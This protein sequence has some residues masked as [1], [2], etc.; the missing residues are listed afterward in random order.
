[1]VGQIVEITNP[2][3]WLNKHRGFLEVRHDGEKL[4]QVPLDDIAAI[5]ISVPGCSVSTN[6][7]D[8]LAQRNIPIAI[9]GQ[10]YLPSTWMLPVQGYN[11]QFHVMRAQTNITEPKRKRA[12][13]TIIKAKI[14][15]QAEVLKRAGKSPIRLKWL[16]DN[17]RS[18]DPENFEAQA[19]R[20]Y[21]QELFGT[22]FRR[23]REA[24]GINAALNYSYAVIRASVARGLVGAGLHPS[25]SLHHKNPQNPFNLV[26]DIMEPFR[27]IADYLI[28]H[29]L[30]KDKYKNDINEL[31][32]EIKADLAAL[33][34]LPLPVAEESSPLSQVAVRVG[35]SIAAYYM[36]ETD[37]LFMP[38]LPT[39]L[40]VAT[41]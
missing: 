33:I 6:L 21:W 20:A 1:M 38:V 16:A 7:L 41:L 2:G 22:D 18:G 12:W 17:V 37:L 35:R 31:N 27:P 9:C 10:N 34:T 14:S 11:R 5:I 13:Q 19:A 28:H 32:A 40:D 36:G 26:D 23:N 25:F 4:G 39:P 29:K 30:N 15:N 8:Q 24:L 3:H